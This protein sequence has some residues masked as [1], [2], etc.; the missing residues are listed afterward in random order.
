MVNE[1]TGSQ[2][3]IS[4]LYVYHMSRFECINLEGPQDRL[5]RLT[6]HA[7]VRSEACRELQSKKGKKIQGERKNGKS[8]YM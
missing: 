1:H 4:Y 8:K 2:L 6:F 3:L 5:E 7:K